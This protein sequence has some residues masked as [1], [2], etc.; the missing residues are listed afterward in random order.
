MNEIERKTTFGTSQNSN[1]NEMFYL[2]GD[3]SKFIWTESGSGDTDG[4]INEGYFAL[5]LTGSSSSGNRKFTSPSLSNYLLNNTIGF[6]ISANAGT[7]AAGSAEGNGAVITIKLTDGTNSET[8]L[9]LTGYARTSSGGTVPFAV[10]VRTFAGMLNLKREGGNVIVTIASTN[11]G[12]SSNYSVPSLP[13][14]SGSSISTIS[15]GTVIDVSSWTDLKIELEL[16]T[17]NLGGGG[18]VMSVL[19]ITPPINIDYKLG[20]NLTE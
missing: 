5:K 20:S 7:I 18:P 19:S 6:F 11:D 2:W 4:I 17:T 1:Y 14:T 9:N 16:T 13:A 3:D 12:V 15:D 10:G 8:I